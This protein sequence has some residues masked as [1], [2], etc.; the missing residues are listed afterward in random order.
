MKTIALIFDFDDTLLPD[1]TSELLNRHGVDADNFWST[2]ARGLLD[3]GYEPTLAYLNLLIDMIGPGKQ[4]GPL[5][6]A[7]LRKFGGTIDDT[8]YPGVKSLFK[9]LRTLVSQVSGDLNIEFYIISG[10]LLDVIQGSKLVT[11]NFTNVYGCQFGEDPKTGIIINIKRTISFTEKTRYLFEINKGI[12]PSDTEKNQYVVNKDVPDHRRRVPFKN[13]IYVGD[14]LTDIS[15]FSLLKKNGGTAFGIFRPAEE[16]SAR[17]AFLEF[18]Q[19]G[20]VL[21]M[22][23]PR[24]GKTAELG[25]LLRA[26]VTNIA[27]RIVIDGSQAE[28][29]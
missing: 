8:F 4:L 27:S 25:A 5:T 19:T 12:R 9:D 23:A 14:G 16:K 1:S 21:S 6:N 11:G 20:R 29:E 7:D 2:R 10:G 3:Q 22:H 24:Y 15:C 28:F 26:A 17:K 13:M 18:L